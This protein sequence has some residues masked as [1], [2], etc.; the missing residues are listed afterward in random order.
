MNKSTFFL[1]TLLFFLTG[2]SYGQLT[3]K[4]KVR[5]EY[6]NAPLPF[7]TI[8]AGTTTFIT[9]MNGVFTLELTKN[10]QRIRISYPGFHPKQTVVNPT[11]PFLQID[12]TRIE[13]Q[14]QEIQR[15]PVAAAHKIMTAAIAKKKQYNPE[16]TLNSFSFKSYQKSLITIDPDSIR[17]QPDSIFRVRKDE[18]RFKEVDSSA[19]QLKE[20]MSRTHLYMTETAINVEYNKEQG[21]KE[22]IAANKMAGLEEPLYRLLRVQLQSFSFYDES[23]TLLGTTYRSPLS[24]NAEVTYEYRILD[25]V[26][27]DGRP[28]YMIHFYP[29]RRFSKPILQGVLFIDTLSLGLQKGVAQLNEGLIIRAQQNFK[30]FPGQD[31]WFP[32]N[33]NL[34]LQKGDGK[35]PVKLFDRILFKIRETSTNPSLAHTNRQH[36]DKKILYSAQQFNTQISFN[37][38]TQI[39][40][41]PRD[42]AVHPDAGYKPQSY[43][44]TQRAT[45]LNLREANTY[46]ELDSIAEA[47]QVNERLLWLNKLF[48]GY[49]STKYIDFDLKYLLKYNN[50]EAFRMGMGA[51]TNDNFSRRFRIKAYGVYGTKDDDFKYGATTSYKLHKDNNTWVGIDYKDDLVETGSSAY[52]TDGRTFYVF[53]PRL[54]NITS[55][56][57]NKSLS[58]FVSHEINPALQVKLQWSQTQTEPTYNYIYLKEGEFY[59][60]YKTNTTTFSLYWA[61]FN[62]YLTAKGGNTIVTPGFPQFNFQVSQGM[63][64]VMG[65][66]FGF[67]KAQ[68]RIRHMINTLGAGSIGLSFNGA[69]AYGDLPITELF[70]ASPNQPKADALMQRFS[71]AGRDSFETMYFDEFFSDRYFSLQAKYFAP[72]FKVSQQIQPQVIFITRYALGAIRDLENHSG[73]P[74][75]SLE[76]GYLESGLEFNN[77]FS[78][79]GLSTMYRYGPNQLPRFDDNISLKFTFYLSLGI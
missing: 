71:V 69:I 4:G 44:A 72:P 54:F 27:T 1:F 29:R 33:A 75:G 9:D 57:R 11:S 58:G 45:P 21:R 37:T 16:L 24:K 19:Y 6:T 31:L 56:H 32:V 63:E 14:S 70:H 8:Q 48:T 26:N 47:T 10:Q 51:I 79:F 30:Y 25:T 55:F 36:L 76:K 5:A 41:R 64:G 38:P 43:W 20:Q 3:L 68:L 77:I 13:K 40:G 22:T 53:E 35:Q 73:I 59:S 61:P 46:V 2:W 12:L 62:R 60:Q 7:A 67:T 39:T 28:G 49:L 23:Y 78:G 17:E 15:D 34:E 42:I 74:F 50:Y 52:L 65:S 66:D 18:L